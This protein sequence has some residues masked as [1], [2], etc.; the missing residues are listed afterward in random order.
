MKKTIIILLV[1]YSMIFVSAW[2]I[3]D[4][5]DEIEI[6]RINIGYNQTTGTTIDG[7]PRI[8]INQTLGFTCDS[9]VDC[10]LDYYVNETG[11]TM[12]GN[13]NMSDN[14]ITQIDY[15]CLDDDCSKHIFANDTGVYIQ[16]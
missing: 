3:F 10:E 8:N 1:L 11:D 2:W 4:D 15:L 7:L 5:D 12:T 6:P 16:G 14:N 13:L 9:L